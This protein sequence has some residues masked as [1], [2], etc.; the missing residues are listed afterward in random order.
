M[1]NKEIPTGVGAI[2]IVIIAMT[3]G[4][5]VWIYEKNQ[6]EIN[7]NFSTQTLSK[8]IIY[9]NVRVSDSQIAFNFQV[10]INWLAETRHDRKTDK[11]ID[12]WRPFPNASVSGG[13]NI[14][15]T[16]IGWK[17]TDFYFID[18]FPS[19]DS[20]FNKL[21]NNTYNLANNGQWSKETVGGLSAEVFTF[22]VAKDANGGEIIDESYNG[23]KVYYINLPNTTKTLIIHKQAK[24]DNKFE[25]YSKHLF[26]SLKFES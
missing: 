12:L 7:Q 3:I 18:D 24:G 26:G 5:L 9:K 2:I 19:Q 10:P 20:Y 11:S 6:P 23:G 8:K 13:E 21:K 22:P 4:S 1:S 14:L 17:Q 15:Y 16:D 25:N